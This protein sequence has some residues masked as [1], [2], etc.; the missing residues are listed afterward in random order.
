MKNIKISKIT[1]CKKS[2]YIKPTSIHFMHNDRKR[3]WDMVKT[4]DSVAILLYHEQKDSFVFV[5]QFRPSIYLRNKNGFTHELC[6]GIMD[7]N[8]SHKQTALEEI[9]EET[10]YKVPKNKIKKIASFYTSVGIAGGKQKLFF[11]KIDESM[12][13]SDGG[14]DENEEIEVVFV[15]RKD[16]KK[17]MFDKKI[18][19]TSGLI[20]AL[21]WFFYNKKHKKNK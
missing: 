17:F 13:V 10:G 21:F 8:L 19:T 14:G 15:K 2:Q 5:K 1:K 16:A 6:A 9:E 3:R 18:A 12:R 7:K 11:A 20:L 4:H